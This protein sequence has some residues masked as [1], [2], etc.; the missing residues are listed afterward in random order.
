MTTTTT[1]YSPTAGKSAKKGTAKEMEAFLSCEFELKATFALNNMATT[2]MERGCYEQAFETLK[3]TVMSLQ[4]AT[5]ADMDEVLRNGR[6]VVRQKLKEAIHRA[7]NPEPFFLPTGVIFPAINIVWHDDPS[8]HLNPSAFTFVRIQEYDA[9][10]LDPSSLN[11]LTAIVLHN[12]ALASFCLRHCGGGSDAIRPQIQSDHDA[13]VILHLA[14]HLLE[15]SAAAESRHDESSRFAQVIVMTAVVLSTLI[16]SLEAMG[17]KDE[18]F[19]CI[20]QLDHV[21]TVS[22]VLNENKVGKLIGLHACAA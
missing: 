18:A 21:R 12:F 3:G 5:D 15:D 11:L 6:D 4:T 22:S 9:S 7:T 19:A 10:L 2:M 8:F 14:R 1:V 16:Q 13:I 20:C 17:H